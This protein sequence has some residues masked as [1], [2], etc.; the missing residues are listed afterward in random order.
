MIFKF[1][2]GP[3]SSN[4]T[5]VILKEAG[6]RYLNGKKSLIVGPSTDALDEYQERFSKLFPGM[7]FEV[8][9]SKLRREDSSGSVKVDVERAL[10]D[11]YLGD[12]RVLAICHATLCKLGADL[13]LTGWHCFVDE[14]LDVFH[15][16]ELNLRDSH[17]LLTEFL[18]SEP[19]GP[20]YSRLT[21]ANEAALTAIVEN[22]NKDAFR[23]IVKDVAAK[24]ANPHYESYTLRVAYSRLLKKGR[25]EK[26]LYC[27]SV[28]HPRVVSAFGGVT[29]FS[30]RFPESL[31]YHLWA[32][33]GI[34]WEEDKRLT[35]QLSFTAH[36]GYEETRIYWGFECN[37][38]KHFRDKHEDH[39]RDF[40]GHALRLMDG[41]AFVR[42]ENNDIK[43]VSDLSKSGNGE[44]LPGRAHG[45]NK[46]RHIDHA[47]IVPAMNYSETASK[48]LARR[49]QFAWEQQI[50]SFA[51]HNI[52]QAVSRTS[53]RDRDLERERIWV[54]PSRQ[55]AEWLSSVLHGSSCISLALNQPAAGNNGR[56]KAFEDSNARK[57]QSKAITRTKTRQV[58]DFVEQI[59]VELMENVAFFNAS[60]GDVSTLI[61]IGNFVANYRA[62]WFDI[63]FQKNGK[64]IAMKEH[65]YINWLKKESKKSYVKKDD[66]PLISPAFYNPLWV[67]KGKRGKKNVVFASGIML[68]FDNTELKPNELATLFGHIQMVT[69]STFSNSPGSL[70][71]RA[72]IPTTRPMF[73]PEYTT[74]VDGIIQAI[75]GAGYKG[76]DRAAAKPNGSVSVSESARSSI[77]GNLK[78]HGIDMSK[79]GPY[80]LFHLP[81]RSP[82]GHSFCT[83]HSG[84][85]RGPLDVNEWL[86]SLPPIEEPEPRE[87]PSDYSYADEAHT[88]TDHQRTGLEDSMREWF[89]IGTLR[90][91]GDDAMWVLYTRLRDLHLPLDLMW[92]QLRVAADSANTPK[93]RHAQVDYLMNDLKAYRD[94]MA[95]LAG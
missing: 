21:S 82:S 17:Q 19:V 15:P 20:D 78:R 89:S 71:Y 52:Y 90:G 92:E 41:R 84:P 87:A 16:V 22:R 86:L 91:Q 50:V 53:M 60:D 69:Y 12:S 63:K 43:H 26:K 65:E 39:Y 24:I 76:K 45:L 6:N 23:E 72:Y 42:L 27:Y 61:D 36:L 37:F 77:G 83:H 64:V 5:G 94:R 1:V 73:I 14:T 28:L 56:P 13:D 35:E 30:A 47:I 51:C 95:L 80:S 3:T 93:D 38:S 11:E 8:Y 48:F 9:H 25:E 85:G 49:Y 59:G 44:T 29:V 58:G 79:R 55:H 7:P 18:D 31:H 68:D 67:G 33:E 2:A 88:L 75:E 81:C 10:Q 40:I 66:V 46:F 70:R 32:C 62:S 74:I 34:T 54:V 4:K 57:K